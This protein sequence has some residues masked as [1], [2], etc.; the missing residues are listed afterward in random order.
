MKKILLILCL[1]TNPVYASG[2][3]D[4]GGKLDD[5]DLS[6]TTSVDYTWPAGKFERDIEFDYRYK[7]EDDIRSTSKGLIEFKQRY[8]FHNKHYT[9]GL[10]RYDYNEFRPINSRLQSSIG[11]GYKILRTERFKMSNEFAIG[12][13][14]TDIGN[15]VLF[16]NSLWFF[17]EVAPKLNF[18]NKFLYE[19]ADEPLIRN[20]TSFDYL[21]TDKIKIGLKNIYTKDPHN[22]N[23]LYFNVGYIF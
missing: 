3:I 14:H 22:D 20:E 18:S 23:I 10:A 21:L 17:Y 1:I 8:E 19:A 13:L 11:W 15:E 9:F 16:R 5:G 7:D 12:A 2:Q 6:I 4:F